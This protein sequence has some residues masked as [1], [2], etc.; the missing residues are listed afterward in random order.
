VLASDDTLILNIARG[1][2]EAFR[3]LYD[4]Y[5]ARLFGLIRTIMGDRREAEDVLQ[6]VFWQVW[7]SASRY[8]ASHGCAAVWIIMIARSRAIDAMRQR[9]RK[10]LRSESAA[11]ELESVAVRMSDADDDEAT[12]AR[13]AL[14]GLPREQRESI[15]LAFYRGYTHEQIARIQGVP[16]G[17]VKTR[18]RLGIRRV[19]EMMEEKRQVSAT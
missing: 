14:D 12:V 19:R 18:I 15:G 6:E 13:Q 10:E 17:T 5:A 11:G 9:R 16:L 1:D 2:V 4:R 7:R 3:A 8:D